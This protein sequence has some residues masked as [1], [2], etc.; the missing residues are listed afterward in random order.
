M[1]EKPWGDGFDAVILGANLM[2]SIVTDRDCKRAQKNLM[3]R[4]YDAL[5]MGGRLFI[6]YDC[7]Y[8]LSEWTPA[9]SEWVCFEGMD[10]HGTCGRYIV[11]G[12]TVND[13]TR[14]VSG[15]RRWEMT[16]AS[17]D[18]FTHAEKSYQYFP[19]LEQVCAWLYRVGFTV[20]SVKGGYGGEPFDMEHRRAVIWARKVMV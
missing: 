18:Q 9:T 8:R 3:E 4:A 1:I 17:G 13:R 14:I 2:V 16:T 12:G 10:D 11:S 6:D 15:G 20:E 19:S 7:P 5:K